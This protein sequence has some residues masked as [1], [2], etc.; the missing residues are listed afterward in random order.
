M[1]Y[2]KALLLAIVMFTPPVVGAN[3]ISVCQKIFTLSQS[4]L[5]NKAK[6]I[7]KDM[8]MSVLPPKQSENEPE[9]LRSMREIVEEVYGYQIT[10]QFA[11]SVYRAELCVLRERGQALQ[12]EF[13]K[14]LPE[15]NSCS[16]QAPECAM[17]L[18]GSKP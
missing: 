11:Y 16:S 15:L 14:I 4:A 9:P 6:G 5:S 2:R 3:D 8:L 10:N 18:A 7:N 12:V 17:Q 13:A 1:K